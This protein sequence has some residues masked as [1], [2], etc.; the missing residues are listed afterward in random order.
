M[1]ADSDTPTGPTRLI[2]L[3][4]AGPGSLPDP[5]QVLD[6]FT[7]WAAASGRELYPHQEEAALEIVAGS[8]VI[9]ATPTGSGKSLIAVAALFNALA[10][11]RR[12]FYTAPIKALVSEK[13][14]ELVDLFGADNVGMITGDS[15]VNP[16]APVICCTAE[17]LAG[18]A[19]RTGGTAAAV[20]APRDAVDVAV[21]DEFHYYGDPQRGWAWQVPLLELPQ[22]QFV[23]MSA[24]LGNVDFFADDLRNRSGREVAVLSGVQR[25]IPLFYN[26]VTEPLQEHLTELLQTHRAPV[27]LVHFTQQAALERAQALTSIAVA[28]RAQRD[29]IAEFIGDFRFTSKFGKTLS[30]VLRHGIGVHHAGM[31]PKYRRLVEKLAQAGLLKVISGTDTLGVGINVPIRTVLLTGL[32]K[33]DGQRTRLLNAREFHQVAGRAGRAGFDTAGDVVVLAPEHEI[34]NARLLAKAGDDPAKRRKVVRRKPPEGFVSW[35]E[36]TYERL[37]SAQPEQLTSHLAITHTVVLGMLGRPGDAVAAIRRLIESS[38]EPRER[39]RRHLLR[40]IAIGRGLLAAGVVRRLDQPDELGRRYV[41]TVDL[42][43]DFALDQPLAPFALAALELLD[44]DADSYHLD[45]VSVVESV[46]DSPGVVLAAQRFHARGEAVAAMKAEG[47]EYD[48]RMELLEEVDHPQPLAEL[49]SAG[50]ESYR[51]GHPWVS[52][53]APEPKSV[54]RDLYERAMTFNEYVSFYGLARSEGVLLRYL[55]DAYRTL[56]RMVPTGARTSELDDLIAWLGELVRG[57]DSS[58]LDEWE[59][60]TH[61]EDAVAV[62]GEIRPPSA[63]RGISGN[64]RGFTVLVRNALFRRVELAARGAWDALAELES[65]PGGWTAARWEAAMDAY[66]DEY[67]PNLGIGPDARNPALLHLDRGTGQWRVRQVFDDPE[68]DRDWGITATVDLAASDEAGEVV[69]TVTDVGPLPAG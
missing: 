62:D 28:D 15:S 35:G 27:Y 26:Y 56:R 20:T 69:L 43:P 12:G 29:R 32:S 63:S 21:M 33:Y 57:V 41:L 48:E 66:A 45:V 31:L 58:L 11:G 39:Q 3:L 49:L 38:H 6:L 61:P 59:A 8:H 17:I 34:E 10:H 51:R 40:A 30:R 54:V 47:I 46:L 65:G 42:P 67:G 4:P 50:F 68:G 60:L 53:F 16:H 25:P 18:V 22:T 64:E 37:V 1:P 5:D 19:L 24:T 44:A 23:L 2:D 13:F 52:E 14:F 7:E 55:S 9:A 36:K